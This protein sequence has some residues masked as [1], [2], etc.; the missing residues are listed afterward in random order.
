MPYASCSCWYQPAPRPSST[1]PSDI[2]STWATLIAS[3]PGK[4]NV[5]DVTSVPRRIVEVSLAIP[6]KVTQASVGPGRP[7]LSPIARKWSLRKNAPKPSRSARW[8]T[9]RSRP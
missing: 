4:R 7:S 1:R 8:A 9:A 5:I 2:S 6:P 3:G